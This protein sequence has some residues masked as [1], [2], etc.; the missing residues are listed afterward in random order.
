[1]LHTLITGQNGVL[2]R[3]VNFA[4]VARTR[5]DCIAYSHSWCVPAC[6]SLATGN[7]T[8]SCRWQSACCGIEHASRTRRPRARGLRLVFN[9]REHYPRRGANRH[10][11]GGVEPQGIR[12]LPKE[13]RSRLCEDNGDRTRD[14]LIRNQLLYP[15]ELYPPV[16]VAI[17]CFVYTLQ[18]P[19][20]YS[21]GA[22]ARFTNRD[23]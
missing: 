16:Q 2:L 13:Q 23:R 6:L 14:S 10:P 17:H 7:N 21:V 1:M 4:Q 15:T 22:Q 18:S 5:P 19:C 20:G 3:V 9:P 12:L 8:W 11:T